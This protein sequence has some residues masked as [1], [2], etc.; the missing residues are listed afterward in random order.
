[1]KEREGNMI[2]K[3]NDCSVVLLNQIQ[4]KDYL[5]AFYFYGNILSV[6]FTIFIL[7]L[8]IQVNS[9]LLKLPYRI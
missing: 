2:L 8:N 1:M 6:M 5:N 3:L 9:C 4:Y 7:L